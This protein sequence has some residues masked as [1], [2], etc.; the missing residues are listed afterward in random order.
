MQVLRLASSHGKDSVEHIVPDLARHA[1]PKVKVLV[2][3]CEVVPL[4]LADVF[5]KFRVMQSTRAIN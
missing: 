4:H 1:K 2:V 5:G 3:M